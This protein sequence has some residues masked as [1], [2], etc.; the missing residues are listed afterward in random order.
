M[1]M[2]V[3]FY[4]FILLFIVACELEKEIDYKTIYERDRLI[5]HGY[6][7]TQEGVQVVIKKSIPPNDIDKDDDVAGVVA[8]VYC[9]NVAVGELQPIGTGQYSL[10]FDSLWKRNGSYKVV[11]EANGFEKIQSDEQQL[12]EKVATDSVKVIFDYSSNMNNLIMWFTNNQ[13]N[14][15]YYTNYL[16]YLDG[17]VENIFYSEDEAKFDFGGLLRDLPLGVNAVEYQFRNRFDSI[18][19]ELYNL[20]PDFSKFLYSLDQYEF[21]NQDP[22]F[23]QTYPVYSNFDKGYGFF[24]A[25][26]VNETIIFNHEYYEK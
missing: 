17:E 26:S 12:P 15:S 13:K 20:S 24:G 23:E 2:K 6:I 25:Y 3:F 9:D 16:I 19:V 14:R 21:T 4:F 11:V 7:S 8:K 5:V 18:K 1:K 22:F 10:P